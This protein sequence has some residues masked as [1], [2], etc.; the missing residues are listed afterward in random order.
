MDKERGEVRSG[1]SGDEGGR[2]WVRVDAWRR[3]MGQMCT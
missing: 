1:G 2:G 3:Y